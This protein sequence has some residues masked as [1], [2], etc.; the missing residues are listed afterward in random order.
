M[1]ESARAR[2]N[3]VRPPPLTAVDGGTGDMT[4]IGLGIAHRALLAGEDLSAATISWGRRA[5]PPPRLALTDRDLHLMA[6]LHGANYL[7]TSQLA[8][9]GWGPSHERAAQ[10]RLKRLHDGGYVDRSARHARTAAPSGTTGSARKA[11]RC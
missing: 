10:M 1:R 7:S 3:G 6:L 11:S 2:L 5:Q 8:V 9:L 4:N